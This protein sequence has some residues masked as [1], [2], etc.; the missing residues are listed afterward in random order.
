MQASVLARWREQEYGAALAR[1]LYGTVYATSAVLPLL[2]A[3]GMQEL[4]GVCMCL[5]ECGCECSRACCV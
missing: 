4:F 5:H 1:L 3:G 2:D